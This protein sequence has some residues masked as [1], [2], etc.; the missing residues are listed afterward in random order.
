LKRLLPLLAVL[1][2][3]ASCVL[4]ATDAAAEWTYLNDPD[5]AQTAATVIVT[6]LF[7]P[8]FALPAQP[9]SVL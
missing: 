9:S 6:F 3:A 7:N 8:L 4:S 5:R 1:T 2:L